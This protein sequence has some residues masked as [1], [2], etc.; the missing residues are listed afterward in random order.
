M[1]RAAGGSRTVIDIAEPDLALCF[2][3]AVAVLEL[4]RALRFG[5]CGS[6]G[7][8]IAAEGHL[9]HR[10]QAGARI[11]HHFVAA[12]G[13][14]NHMGQQYQPVAVQGAV[15]GL[16]RLAAVFGQF[17][18]AA[19]AEGVFQTRAIVGHDL[20]VLSREGI[21]KSGFAAGATAVGRSAW[22]TWTSVRSV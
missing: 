12:L 1:W 13:A 22:A 14:C 8:G 19:V 17:Q 9:E 15:A 5:R 7:R 20:Q 4:R 6:F 10:H 18:L 11:D 2:A 3:V 16:D 21:G